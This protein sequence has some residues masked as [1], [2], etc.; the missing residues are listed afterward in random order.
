MSERRSPGTESTGGW[1]VIHEPTGRCQ[2]RSIWGTVDPRYWASLDPGRPSK[3]VALILD[4][5]R[6]V[7]PVVTPDDPDA[8]AAIIREHAAPD[9][10]ETGPGRTDG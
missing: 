4:L 2:R 7:S 9:A 1:G 5:G 8:V 10:T 6:G 3:R